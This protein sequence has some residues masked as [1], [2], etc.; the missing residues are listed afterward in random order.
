[1]PSELHDYVS[2]SDLDAL[3]R[4]TSQAHGLPA[5]IYYDP[6]FW[7]LEKEKLFSKTW[8]ACAFESDLPA[9]G[10]VFPVSLCGWEIVLTRDGAGKLSAFHNI[11]RHRSMRV[12][13]QPCTEVDR[14]SCPWHAWTYDLNGKLVATPN[15]GGKD[16]NQLEGIDKNDLGLKPIRCESWQQIIFI[17][18]DGNAPEL[19]KHLHPLIK[20]LSDYDLDLLRY[21]GNTDDTSFKGNWKFVVE[22]GVENYHMPWVHPEGGGH[23]GITREDSDED[24]C[25]VGIATMWE[26]RTPKKDEKLLPKFPHLENFKLKNGYGW[27]DLYLFV[28]PGTTVV[29]MMANHFVVVL[30]LPISPEKCLMRRAFYFISDAAM[31]D[32]YAE[33]RSNIKRFWNSFGV[34]DQAIVE[35]VQEQQRQRLE[36]NIPTRFS[37]HWETAVHR[38]QKNLVKY[39]S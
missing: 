38:F 27:E 37:G 23:N 2:Q 5:K 25:Y 20:R 26:R 16:I 6:G 30:Y 19:T 32:D 1:M 4:P 28:H 36:T 29:E 14:M 34:Q 9:P 22:G 8:M 3:Q 15:L 12:A 24:G 17:N 33:I 18:L 7:E 11:C 39:L 31:S 10:S 13:N 21:G 35:V